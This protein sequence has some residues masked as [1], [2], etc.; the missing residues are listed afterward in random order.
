MKHTEITNTM[1]TYQTRLPYPP[2]DG[3][4]QKLQI[5]GLMADAML[6]CFSLIEWATILSLLNSILR[7][8]ISWQVSRKFVFIGKRSAPYVLS[9]V[10]LECPIELFE[11]DGWA[12]YA[13]TS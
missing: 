9:M 3:S 1:E 8:A 5:E 6:S 13:G 12:F 4:V 7:S 11:G 2:F 10:G